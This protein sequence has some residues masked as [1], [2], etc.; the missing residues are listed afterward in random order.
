VVGLDLDAKVVGD[1]QRGQPPLHEPGLAE[2]IQAQ[3]LTFTTDPA[4]ALADAEVLWVAFD[5]P[6][7]RTTRPTSPGCAGSSTRSQPCATAHHCPR[8]SQVPV[9]FTAAIEKAWAGRGLHFAVSPRISGSA[10]RSTASQ[11]R[12]RRVGCREEATKAK[13]RE[14]FKPFCENLVWMSVESAR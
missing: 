3:P 5:T 4:A 11:T 8:S 1:L 6:V 7:T 14:L 10:R 9:G 12:A 2:L 13:L